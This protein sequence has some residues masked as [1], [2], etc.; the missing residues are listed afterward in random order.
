MLEREPELVDAAPQWRSIIGSRD[1]LVEIA[2]G[3]PL[4]E[5]TNEEVSGHLAIC[6]ELF[7]H[8][9]FVYEFGLVAVIWSTLAVEAGTAGSTRRRCD[10][11]RR[12]VEVDRQG[13]RTQLDHHCPRRAAPRWDGVQEP[14]RPREGV[15]GVDSPA[16]CRSARDGSHGDREDLRAASRFASE[17]TV[18]SRPV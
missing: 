12:L 1:A 17:L 16:G 14:H 9:Y 15:R 3:W 13:A 11:V 4:D 6:R 5:R 7:V 2:N 8:S 10:A 18:A